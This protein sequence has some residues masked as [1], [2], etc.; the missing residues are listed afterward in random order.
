M[1]GTL[2]FINRVMQDRFFQNRVSDYL[3]SLLILLAGFF[4]IRMLKKYILKRIVKWAEKTRTD[5]DDFIIRIGEKTVFPLFYFGVL[6]LAIRGLILHRSIAKAF[7]IFGLL[8]F[9]CMGIN[10]VIAFSEYALTRLWIKGKT[11]VESEKQRLRG[12]FPALRVLIWIVGFIFLLD[13]LGFK[14][15][16]VVTTLGIGGVAVALAS[17]ALLKDLFS[18]FSILFDRP[19]ELGDFIIVGDYLGTVERIGIKTTRVR[20]L[21]GEQLIFSN[22]DLT[23]SRVRNYKLMQ[24]RRVVFKIGV[25]YETAMDRIRDVLDIIRETIDRIEGATLDRSH[26]SSFGDFSLNFEIVYY[27]ETGDYTKYMDIQQNINFSLK[28]NFENK[29]IE[30]AYPTQTLYINKQEKPKEVETI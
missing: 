28:E 11:D 15:S 16:S 12:L 29:G 8:L 1:E 5:W 21:G 25:T 18:Y 14:I 10:F 2:K 6:Y 23:D 19:F 3:I 20:S 24:R 22:S 4:I 17:Q 26:F 30:F 27:V 7:S 13:N 9:T